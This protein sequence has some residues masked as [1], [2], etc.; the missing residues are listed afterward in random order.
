MDVSLTHDADLALAVVVGAVDT[1]PMDRDEHR[2]RLVE[3]LREQGR[4]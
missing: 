4:I 1:P 3:W 2:A